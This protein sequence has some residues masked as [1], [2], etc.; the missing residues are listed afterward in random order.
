M[1]RVGFLWD[2]VCSK[3]NIKA[4]IIEAAKHKEKRKDVKKIIQ[5]IDFFVSQIQQMLNNKTFSNSVPQIRYRYEKMQNKIR[6]I[7]VLP[8]YPDHCVHHAVIRV[9]EP[10][11]RRGMYYYC[12]ANVPGRG[13]SHV[14]KRISK[15][16]NDFTNIIVLNSLGCLD[17]LKLG[18][19]SS[20]FFLTF[21]ILTP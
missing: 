3:E 9:I 17:F 6:E 12:C 1:K 14:R 15:I 8:F 11:L 16:F 19:S 7:S 10:L 5:D 2:K 20:R 21:L 4:A 13:E 18:F